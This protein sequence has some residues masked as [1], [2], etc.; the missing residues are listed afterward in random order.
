MST[1]NYTKQSILVNCYRSVLDTLPEN[2]VWNEQYSKGECII[3]I[4]I[5]GVEG[6]NN[7]EELLEFYNIDQSTIREVIYE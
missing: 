5:N 6:I 3:E 4:N 7:E 1:T 2:V